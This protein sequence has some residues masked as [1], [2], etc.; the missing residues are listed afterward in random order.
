[1]SASSETNRISIYFK[2]PYT[3]ITT[4]VNVDNSLTTIEFL[5]YVN[6][7]VRNKL[8]INSKYHIELVDT[9]KPEGELAAPMEPRYDETLLQR[10]GSNNTLVTFYAR[11]VNPMTREFTR[12]TDYSE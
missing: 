9:G 4:V 7:H 11:P 8:N 6:D 12:V 10:Y 5:E 2:I 1:M 3:K